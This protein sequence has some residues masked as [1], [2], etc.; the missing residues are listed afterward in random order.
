MCTSAFK[1]LSK[2]REIFL[3]LFPS[4]VGKCVQWPAISFNRRGL[5]ASL[6]ILAKTYCRALY[7]HTRCIV[8]FPCSLRAVKRRKPRHQYPPRCEFR[9][10]VGTHVG[11][12][13][14]AW[15]SYSCHPSNRIQ[16]PQLCCLWVRSQ[17]HAAGLLCL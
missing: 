16:V 17:I 15:G 7:I 14:S 6:T 5:R 8:M 12:M 10:T 13:S 2:F 3:G 1:R 11:R 4:E 9:N